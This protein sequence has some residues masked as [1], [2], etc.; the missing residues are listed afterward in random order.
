MSWYDRLVAL[1][2]THHNYNTSDVI[3]GGNSSSSNSS[4]NSS[5]GGGG[6]GSGGGDAHSNNNNYIIAKDDPIYLEPTTVFF[7]GPPCL[8]KRQTLRILAKDSRY[9]VSR[10]NY[11]TLYAAYMGDNDAIMRHLL[12]RRIGAMIYEHTALCL[13]YVH[14]VVATV[15]IEKCKNISFIDAYEFYEYCRN[16]QRRDSQRYNSWREQPMLL[17]L[18]LRGCYF[19]RSL[20]RLASPYHYILAY[21]AAMAEHQ[22]YPRT[23]MLIIIDPNDVD[24]TA[25]RLGIYT[26]AKNLSL[27]TS[28]VGFCHDYGTVIKHLCAM[29]RPLSII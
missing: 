26:Y 15:P 1:E 24:S 17:C 6:G 4:L 13:V 29:H 23:H 22:L 21:L 8:G 3:S 27:R 18:D 19:R 2:K 25:E 11:Q 20:K 10:I 7:G 12:T 9:L 5:N 14:Q 16:L 28:Q